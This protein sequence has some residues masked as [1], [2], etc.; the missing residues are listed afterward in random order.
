MVGP[1]GASYLMGP[2]LHNQLSFCNNGA[3]QEFQLDELLLQ[4]PKSSF[5][6]PYVLLELEVA[7]L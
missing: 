3:L 7:P 4:V 6:L 2:C 1:Q 5:K